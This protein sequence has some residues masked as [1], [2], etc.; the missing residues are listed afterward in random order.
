MSSE[1]NAEEVAKIQKLFEKVNKTIL[2]KTKKH[3]ELFDVLCAMK[4]KIAD[5]YSDDEKEA[6]KNKYIV[7]DD[8]ENILDK[9]Q[10]TY[11][12]LLMEDTQNKTI[13]FK[14][15]YGKD[16]YIVLKKPDNMTSIKK[17][18]K[19]LMAKYFSN[20]NE[21]VAFTFLYQNMQYIDIQDDGKKNMDKKTL[22]KK[23]NKAMEL[24]VEPIYLLYLE[25]LVLFQ[26]EEERREEEE[27]SKQLTPSV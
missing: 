22:D 14:N 12:N 17:Q 9:I 1:E 13:K 4:I 6:I 3:D 18:Y 19:T 26:E 2:S 21:G 7:W 10:Q 16:W 11:A 8:F 24:I 25:A 20:I 15:S 27:L 5:A 23:K